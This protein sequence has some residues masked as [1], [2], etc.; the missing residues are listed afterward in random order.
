MAP[1]CAAA[2]GNLN[3]DPAFVCCGDFPCGTAAGDAVSSAEHGAALSANANPRAAK[4][5]IAA[6]EGG[7][8]GAI[9][10]GRE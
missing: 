2:G 6:R 5:E 4:T 7:E 9:G 3:G 10:P 1:L 8:D